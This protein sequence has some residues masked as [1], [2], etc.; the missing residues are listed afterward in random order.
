LKWL[1]LKSPKKDRF[2]ALARSDCGALWI[3]LYGV[4]AAL[5]PSG[6]L[7]L[8]DE[9]VLIAADL[10]L[11]KGS[12]YAS[13]GQL[14][15][16]YDTRATLQSL[17]SEI[18]AVRPSTVVLLGDSFH[19]SRAPLRLCAEDARLIGELA[20]GLTVIWAVGNHDEDLGLEAAGLPGEVHGEV[21][22][23]ALTLRHAPRRGA[24]PGEISGHLHPCA[25]VVSRGR[26]VRRRAFLTDGSR[27]ILPA[28]GA[29]AG[30]LNAC[31]P[32]FADLFAGPPLAGVIGKG[33]VHPIAFAALSGD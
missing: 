19:D 4:H 13:R 16:P 26:G 28:F 21:A 6:A 2:I 8:P 29:Y 33:T 20:R 18:R 23:A 14:L 12:S 3:D 7:W 9:A 25:K 1:K 30:G 27:L 24:Q 15:P 22:F 31:D 17:A 32:A 11:E 5:R 10:H